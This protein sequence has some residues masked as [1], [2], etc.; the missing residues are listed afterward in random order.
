MQKAMVAEGIVDI[1]PHFAAICLE[2]PEL[3]TLSVAYFAQDMELVTPEKIVEKETVF[4]P[5]RHHLDSIVKHLYYISTI[6]TLV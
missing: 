5:H 2:T 6:L 4:F 1:L 3:H